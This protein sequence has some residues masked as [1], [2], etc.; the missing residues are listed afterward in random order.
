VTDTNATKRRRRGHPPCPTTSR[1]QADMPGAVHDSF[2]RQ[3]PPLPLERRYPLPLKRQPTRSAL[4]LEALNLPVGL[5]HALSR[6]PPFYQAQ[7]MCMAAHE[8]S[9]STDAHHENHVRAMAAERDLRRGEPTVGKGLQSSHDRVEGQHVGG[10]QACGSLWH[11][12]CCTK[13]EEALDR[14]AV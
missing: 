12:S 14:P 3:C 8:G 10:I 2:L 5:D 6:H 1:P 11:H 4:S 13:K 9:A 7:A